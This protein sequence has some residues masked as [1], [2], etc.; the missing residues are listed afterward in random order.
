M[1]KNGFS[2][3][4]LITVATIAASV[5]AFSVIAHCHATHE[6]E[7]AGPSASMPTAPERNAAVDK[8]DAML[9]SMWII[10]HQ[11]GSFRG[12]FP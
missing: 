6:K 9:S 10:K 8:N 3:A 1:K 11:G 2:L 5:S 12:N 4:Q 7:S